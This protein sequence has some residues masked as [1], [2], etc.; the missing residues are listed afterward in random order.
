MKRT[1]RLLFPLGAYLLSA[2]VSSP[3]GS[4]PKAKE[5]PTPA[6]GLPQE[7]QQSLLLEDIPHVLQQPDFCGEACVEMVAR[8]AGQSIDQGQVFALTGLDPA[9]GRGAYAPELALALDALGFERGEG[10]F[11]VPANDL[12]AIAAEW[13]VLYE[14][15]ERGIP[16][17]VCTHFD[18]S[19][20]TTEHFRLVLGYDAEEDEVIFHDPA[21]EDGAFVHLSRQDFFELWPLKYQEDSW[22][23]IHFALP[24]PATWPQLEPEQGFSRA[25]VAQHVMRLREDLG[26]EFTVVWEPPFIVIGDESPKA[27][28]KRAEKTVRWAVEHLQA[29]Y[30][31]LPPDDLLEIWLFRDDKSYYSNNFKRFGERDPGTPYGYYSSTYKALVMNIATGS[32]TLVHEIVHP[33]MAANFEACPSWFNEGLA[34]LYEQCGE[35]N[36]EIWGFTNWRL[37]GLQEAIEEGYLQPLDAMMSTTEAAFYEDVDGTN[38]AHARYLMYYLQEEGLLREYYREFKANAASD[39]TGIESLKK[40]LGREDL[41]VFH[42]EWQD[43]VLTLRYPN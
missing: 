29:S 28:R 16:S 17:I 2:C 40:V 4:E 43:W 3:F 13:A 37:A 23:L 35:H 15:L 20:Y 1:L 19:V 32:G 9:K 22:T 11:E 24:T 12:D 26:E 10:W 41:E 34:S 30:F 5:K 7:Q 39:P 31:E 33:F 8:S 21:L 14:R 42:K 25:E 6:Q 38:Y 27:V 36:G 18:K